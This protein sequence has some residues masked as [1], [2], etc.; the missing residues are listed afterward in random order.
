MGL[1]ES[2]GTTR[3]KHEILI[4]S[5]GNPSPD[6]GTRVTVVPT[7]QNKRAANLPARL[8]SGCHNQTGEIKAGS[9]PRLERN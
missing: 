4:T 6:L 5:G 8:C 3:P 7:K 2:A 9:S 1:V